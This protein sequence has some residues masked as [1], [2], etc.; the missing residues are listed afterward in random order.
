MMGVVSG[1]N[2]WED[3]RALFRSGHDEAARF[4]MTK[5]YLVALREKTRMLIDT[6]VVD[7]RQPAA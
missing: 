5:T 2:W 1:P 3:E 4:E 6:W 7:L